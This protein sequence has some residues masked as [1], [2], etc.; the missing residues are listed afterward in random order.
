MR[1]FHSL[2]TLTLKR[3]K[4]TLSSA[5]QVRRSDDLD[6]RWAVAVPVRHAGLFFRGRTGEPARWDSVALVRLRVSMHRE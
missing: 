3:T 1:D 5:R 6:L 4:A 2:C